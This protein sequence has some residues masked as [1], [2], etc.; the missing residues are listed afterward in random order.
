MVNSAKTGKFKRE[1]FWKFGFLVS[2][3]HSQALDLDRANNNTKWKDA[4]DIEQ[5]Q[6]I[7]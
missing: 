1:S 3:V 6:L 4:E 7:E 5:N 2:R